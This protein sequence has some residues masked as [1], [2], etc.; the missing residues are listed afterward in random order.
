MS[1]VYQAH[2]SVL[3]ADIFFLEQTLAASSITLPGTVSPP[4]DGWEGK[5]I[6]GNK[7]QN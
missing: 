5:Q 1:A 7:G 4:G 2:L 3:A 6:I